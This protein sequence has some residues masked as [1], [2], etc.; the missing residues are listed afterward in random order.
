MKREDLRFWDYRDMPREYDRAPDHLKGTT[1][2]Q[3]I[4]T[5]ALVIHTLDVTGQAFLDLFSCK[6]FDHDLAAKITAEF[7][8]GKINAQ[9]SLTRG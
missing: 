3:F 5:S 1:A 2:V 4:S 7:F 9:H 8:G 6:A